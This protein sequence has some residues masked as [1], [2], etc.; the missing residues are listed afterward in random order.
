M[1]NNQKG[2]T[3]VALVIT[4]IILLILAGIS[5]S[6]LTGSG[7]LAKAQDAEKKYDNAQAE[8]SK[9]L[10][11]YESLIDEYVTGV[12]KITD[13]DDTKPSQA[14]P[15]EATVIENNPSKGIVIV[16]K[17][18]NEWT[19]VEVPKTTVFTTAQN[20]T[21]YDNIKADLIAYATEYRESGY[22]DEWYDYCGTTYDGTNQYSQVKYI[23]SSGDLTTIS[24]LFTR[25][26]NYYGTIYTDKGIT[27]ATEYVRGTTYYADITEKLTDTS[28]CGLT[29]NEYQDKYQKMLSSVYTNG[30]FW[31]SRY[32]IGDATATENNITR[33]NGSG[34]T[35]TAVS[36]AD[37]IPYTYVTCSQAQT[38]ASGMSTDTNKT[39]SLLFGIQ[40]DLVCKYLEVKGNWDTTSKTA[41]SYLNSDSTSWGN[42]Y[43]GSL[44]LN[45]GKYNISPNNSTSEWKT[46]DTD[47]ENYVTSS[48]KLSSKCV[49]LTTGTTEE[50]NK[51]NIYDFA[52]NTSEWTLGH[53][54]NN[55]NSPSCA[56]RGGSYA[57][58]GSG[59]PASHYHNLGASGVYYYM[60][61]RSGLY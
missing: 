32:E 46:F 19:W 2:I 47:T 12:K 52:G 55:S 35:G 11:G 8:E 41:I 57:N 27:E 43:E 54:T 22:T 16:D 15:E 53:G 5:I 24:S 50:T 56:Y 28:G 51:M 21:D 37:Q 38:L 49:L 9:T 29:F 25:A 13:T 23:K 59:C 6:A 10:L 42:Y 36:K 26:K 1:K 18:G 44:T 34:I 45:R 58:K 60:A 39:S 3:L 7:L 33:T 17:K 30:G 40:W 20:A 31:I 4:I 48:Q 14:M 61:F